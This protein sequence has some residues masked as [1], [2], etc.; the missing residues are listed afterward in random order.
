MVTFLSGGT[1]TPKLLWGAG[2]VFAPED[3]TVI[4]NTGDDVELGG[5]HVSPD[6]DTVLFERAGILDR[7]TWWGIDGDP[8][9][10]TVHARELAEAVDLPD[11]PAYLPDDQQTSGR[12]LSRWR[13]FAGVPAFMT[14][15]DR[16]RALHMVRTRL[17]ETGQSLTETTR[18]LA[19]AHGLSIELLP[20]S[21]DPVATIIHT[22][23]G[24]QHFQE[25]WVAHG[26]TP[27][28][29]DVEFRGASA[30]SAT[31]TVERALEDPVVIGPA[32]PVTSLGPMLAVDGIERALEGTPV[33]AVS[34][35]LG[36][37]PFSGPAGELMRG[38]G[39]TPGS[40]SMAA[41]LPMVDAFVLDEH[42]EAELDR[43]TIRTDT[44]I[45]TAV[46][47]ERVAIACDRALAEVS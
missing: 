9:V 46:D 44:R 13:R 27:S 35:F 30:A 45:D 17:L 26:G 21:D 25:F 29:R 32:N 14:I 31:R 28:V 34:P 3:T 41:Q 38:L 19:E 2:D 40:A 1:G 33:V 8:T 22:A 43:P 10:T 16:D 39:R 12:R 47:A 18:A 23:E 15:G 24:P 6:I 7:G 5:L 20:M 36:D 11:G 37:E 42:D 4:A